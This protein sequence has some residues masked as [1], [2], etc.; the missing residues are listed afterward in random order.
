MGA[1]N[2]DISLVDHT[3]YENNRQ[4]VHP[5]KQEVALQRFYV[6][7]NFK[8]STVLIQLETRVNFPNLLRR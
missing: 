8:L 2:F 4:I 1:V 7:F 6:P 5:S 3:T